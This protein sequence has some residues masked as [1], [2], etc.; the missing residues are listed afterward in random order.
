MS[1]NGINIARTIKEII[2][3]YLQ[4]LA[5]KALGKSAD[6]IDVT[7]GFFD[8]GMDSKMTMQLVSALE[9]KVGHELYPTLLFEYQ[10]IED[11]G[12]YLLE[13]DKQA[14]SS[15]AMEPSQDLGKKEDPITTTV[16]SDTM[17]VGQETIHGYLQ[18]LAGEALDKPAGSIDVTAGFFDL[19]MDSKM[20]MQL[21]STLEDK[22][23]HELYPTLLFEYQNIEDLSAY[24]LEND[25]EA[26]AQTQKEQTITKEYD[27][28]K[29]RP[30]EN[31][32]EKEHLNIET[33]TIFED[34]QLVE[35]IW[36]DIPVSTDEAKDR[37]NDEYQMPMDDPIAIV[38]ISGRYP[39]ANTI[40]EFWDNLKTGK[41]SISAMPKDRWDK[42]ERYPEELLTGK[43]GGFIEDVD[44]FDPLHF[45]IAP[46]E[47]EFIDPQVRLF[48]EES[49]KTF[50]DAGLCLST[51]KDKNIGVF[52]G[53]MFNSY[54]SAAKNKTTTDKLSFNTGWT[55]AN[56][57]SYHL[58]LTGPSMHVNT[59]CSSSLT[60]VIEACQSIQNGMCTSAIAGG[61][62]LS[63]DALKWEHLHEFGLLGSSTTS[64]SFAEGDGYL[65]GEGVG[66]VLLKPLSKAEQDGDR[67]YGVIK[68]G[69]L[70]H[71]GAGNGFT[72][73]NLKAQTALIKESLERSGIDADAIG[74]VEAAANGSAMG[75]P[76]EI[77]ALSHLFSSGKKKVAI[78]SVKAQIGHL[79]SASG[80]SQLTKVLLQLKH[81]TLVPGIKTQ[82][83]NPNL[84]LKRTSLEINEDLKEWKTTGSRLAMVN[85]F[86]AGGANAHVVVEEYNQKTKKYI[87]NEPAMV[88]LSAKNKDRLKEQVDNLYGFLESNENTNLYDLAYTL[89]IGR[90]SMEE[91]FVTMV[92]TISELKEAL[93]D[94]QRGETTNCL[95]G[96]VQNEKSD[97]ILKGNAGKA[98]IEVAIRDKEIESLMQLWVKGVA[99]DWS[100][101][102]DN[103]NRPNKI[104]LP[105][106]PFAKES[107]WIPELDDNN[108]G[109]EKLHPLLHRNESDFS[110]QKYESTFTGKESFLRNHIAEDKK[111]LPEMA[112]IELAREAGKR[113][114]H[115]NI[116]QLKDVSWSNPISVNGKPKQIHIS[117][118]ED[119]EEINYE[120]YSLS[121][122]KGSEEV[123]HGKGKLGTETLN[124]PT[125][126]D[127][128]SIKEQLPNYKDK[129]A[130]HSLFKALGLN[131]G[132]GFIGIESLHSG[133][134][135]ALVNLSIPKENS[136]STQL[137]V[138][139]S[140][141]QA[142]LSL[143]L[144]A[145]TLNLPSSIKGVY[146]Y[147]DI[148]TV[149]WCYILKQ[150]ENEEENTA[151]CE[152]ELLSDTG[153]VVLRLEDFTV[154]KIKSSK[155]IENVGA[156]KAVGLHTYQSF[157]R[158]E[159]PKVKLET[160]YTNVTLLLAGGNVALAEK[161]KDILELDVVAI[162]E[163]T[164]IEY[165]NEV[166]H[167]VKSKLK[168]K[169]HTHIIVLYANEN[170][171]DYG[172]VSGLLKTAHLESPKITG[173]T[174]GI[175]ELSIAEIDAL[176][177]VIGNEK[178]DYSI[179]VRYNGGEREVKKTMPTMVPEINGNANIKEGGVYLITGGAGGLGYIFARHIS[180]KKDAKLILTGR[181]EKCKL[182]EEALQTINATYHSCDVNSEVAVK[183]LVDKVVD[184]YGTIDGIIHGAGII[185]DN[186]LIQKTKEEAAKVLLPKINGAKNLDQATKTLDLDFVMY[187][188]SLSGVLGN[189][190]QADYSSANSWM[191]NYAQYRNELKDQGKRKG[192]TLS[193]DW[194]LWESGGM[195]IDEAT[196]RY[197]EDK[198]GMQPL[199]TVEGVLAFEAFLDNNVTQGV[200]AYG[201]V[202]KIERKLNVERKEIVEEH[203]N[204]VE[205]DRE[206]LKA[207][208]ENEVT[209][210]I[211]S[212][213]KLDESRL[214]KDTNFSDYGVESAM[215]TIFSKTLNDHYEGLEILPIAFVNN[216][217]INELVTFLMEE[218]TEIII[219]KG[220]G[221]I[222]SKEETKTG[223]VLEPTTSVTSNKRKKRFSQARAKQSDITS[224]AVAI[225]GMSGRFSTIDT[226]EELWSNT[227]SNVALQ[228]DGMTET[229]TD[230]T[231]GHLDI[232]DNGLG[233]PIL[234]ISPKEASQM[235]IQEQLIFEELSKT[236]ENYGIDRKDLSSNATGVFIAAQEIYG[237]KNEIK[238]GQHTLAYLIPNKISYYLNLKGPSE[239]VNAYCTSSYV[240]IHKAIQ[241]IVNGE[242]K[243]A[244]VGGVN[245]VSPEE[246][247]RA[248]ASDFGG[249]FSKKGDTRSFSEDAEGFV[250]SEG[251]GV[252]IIKPL[253]QAEKDKNKIL[254]LVKGSAVHHGGKGFSIEA[255]NARGIKTAIEASIQKSRVSIDTIDYIEAHGI[256]N[257][258]A[259]AIELGAIDA[260]YKKFSKD[261][262]KKWHVGT[263]KPIVGHSELASGMASLIKVLK[264]F[265]H[266]TIPGIAGLENINS[267]LDP[268]HSLILTKESCHWQ[269]GT[270]PRRAG[271]NSYAV[272]GVNAHLI[273]EEYP[274]VK[275]DE[276]PI[277]GKKA[278]VK[279]EGKEVVVEADK[280]QTK[281]ETTRETIEAISNEIFQ[282][283]KEDFDE[284]LSPIDYD[285]DS[286]KVIEFV[287]RI[288]EHFK[289]NVKMGQILGVDD[290][291]SMYDAFE[292]IVD[293]A[294]NTKGDD[295]V[296]VEENLPGSYPL[297]EGQKGLWFIQ[298]ANP[299]STEYNVPLAFSVNRLVD[300]TIIYKAAE[301][302]LEKEPVLRVAF[303]VDNGNGELIQEIQ[304]VSG[305][306]QEDDEILTKEIGQEFETLQAI[307]FELS[308][309][310]TR[311]HIRQDKEAQR[312][313]ILFVVHHIVFDGSSVAPFITGFKGLLKQL[314]SGAIPVKLEEERPYFEF[315]DQENRY[316]KSL[317]SIEDFAFWSK[318]FGNSIEKVE[319]PYDV[320][321]K[322]SLNPLDKE[323]ACSME[324]N[325]EAL[326]QLKH[327]AKS[328]KVNLSVFML[329]MFKVLLYKITNAEEL[330][331]KLP[332]AGRPNEKY[333]NSIGYYINM[334]LAKT[335]VSGDDA[336]SNLVNK[337]KAEFLS[338][339]DYAKYPYPKLLTSLEATKGKGESLF[340]IVYIY[341]NI[342][343]KILK[344]D[345]S[346]D[347]TL[348]DSFRQDV[349]DEYV[350]EII[351]LKESLKVEFKYKK[352][353]FKEETVNAHINYY[354]NIIEEVIANPDQKVDDMAILSKEEEQR[355]L[356]DFNA[357]ESIYPKNKSIVELF[358]DQVKEDPKAIAVVFG[359]ETITYETLEERSNQLATYL[360]QQGVGQET[361][362]G[363]CMDRSIE[364]MVA[365]LGVL[366]AGGAYV[367]IDSEY[368]KDRISYMLEDSIVNG[369][370]KNDVRIILVQEHLKMSILD[371]IDESITAITLLKQWDEN[372]DITYAKGNLE[373]KTTP[374]S[375]AYVIYTSGSTGNPKGVMVEHKSVVRLV[376]NP[377]Y[378]R[379]DKDVTI[380]ATGAFSFDATIFEFFGPLLNGGKLIL[381]SQDVLLNNQS[382]LDT[383]K[384]NKVD[385]M[386]FTSSWLN[387]I[388]DSNI[389]VFKT[390][391]TV[392]V[393]GERL[394]PK[395]IGELRT[396]YPKLEIING[397]GPTENT[398]F[399]TTNNIKEVNGDI[400]IGKPISDDKAYIVNKNNG[401]QP[402][403]VPGELCLTGEGLSRGYLNRKDLTDEKFIE[404]PFGKGKLYRT[405]DLARWNRNG[406]IEYLGRIDNQVKLRGFRI[407]LG[408]I[409]TMLNSQNSI[410]NSTVI[411]K[412]HVGSKQLVAYCVLADGNESLDVLELKEELAKGLPDYMVPPFIVEIDAL[413]L[414]SNGK[415]DRRALLNL[416]VELRGIREYVA[417]S[418]KTEKQLTAIWE[419]VL[420]VNHISVND[421]FFELG[422][423]SLLVTKLLSRIQKEFNV[424]L[425]L[426]SV[427]ESS[428]LVQLAKTVDNNQGNQLP[429]IKVV[430][431]REKQ[432]LSFA[433]QRLWFLN[434]LGEGNRY[435]IPYLLLIKG[436]LDTDILE[437][438]LAYLI[439][440]HEI[441]RTT[442]RKDEKDEAYQYIAEE[443]FFELT[444][445][446]Y[447]D[448]PFLE[449][450]KQ[451]ID[452]YMAFFNE[453]F[454]LST[455][456]LLRGILIEQKD[457][458]YIFG[459]CMH[460]IVSD[461]WS[462]EIIIRE[463]NEIYASYENNAPVKLPQLPVQYLDYTMWQHTLFNNSDFAKGL[464]YWKTHLDGYVDLALPLDYNRPKGLSGK[465]KRISLE[466]DAS[467]KTELTKFSVRSGGTLFTTLLTSVYV[468]L[469]KYSNQEDICV[470]IPVANRPLGA[471][472]NVIGFFVNTLVNRIK[473]TKEDSILEIFAKVQK[474]L[475]QSQ[476]NQNIPFEKIVEAIQPKREKNKAPIFQVMVN[477]AKIEEQ[478]SLGET[479]ISVER[480]EFDKVKFD[481]NFDFMDTMEGGVILSLDY[482]TDIFKPSTANRFLDG[483]QNIL[484]TL[485]YQPNEQLKSFNILTEKERNLLLKGFNDKKIAY[486]KS[487]CIHDLF[488]LQANRTPKAIALVFGENEI[489]YEELEERSRQLA[490]YL[491]DKGIKSDTLV[492]ICMSRSIE[493]VIAMLGV[494][495][496][497]GAYI[498]IDSDYPEDRMSFMINDGIVKGNNKEAVRLILTQEHLEELLDPMV[499]EADVKIE[500]ISS[501]WEN[502][503]KIITTEGV[504]SPVKS[505]NDLAY[506]IYTSGSTGKPKGVLI[507]HRSFLD[508]IQYQKEFFEVDDKDQFLQFSNFS[509][510]AS[511]E[512]I[513]LPLVSG[514]TLHIMPKTDLLDMEKF[515]RVLVG[516][517]ITHLHAVPSFL[518]EIPFV[519]NTKLKRIISGGDVFDYRVLET[520]GDQGIRIID[521][522][523]PTES[524]VS[525]VQ[526]DLELP[527]VEKHIGKPLANTC[528]YVLDEQGN[529]QP[530][531]VP[532]ELCIGG[533][534]LARGYLNRPEL[535][536]EKFID[537]PFGEGKIYKTG[538]LTRWLP[539]GNIE[540]LGRIDHQVKVNGFRIELE[541]IEAVINTNET[542]HNSVVI[543]KEHLGS[544][545]LVAYCVLNEKEGVFS[546]SALKEYLAQRL[547]EYMIPAFILVVDAIPLT[548]NRKVN[549]KEL[550]SRPLI[551]NS[552][553]QYVAPKTETEKQ[554]AV[555]WQD[556][557]DVEKISIYDNFFELGGHSL[558]ITKLLS[559][560]NKQFQV[561]LELSKVFDTP[562][563]EYL[564]RE[565]E[566]SDKQILPP[567][568]IVKD[569]GQLPL[570]YAQQR[571]W[572]LAQLGQGD[573]YH[574]PYVL[575]ING[576]LDVEALESSL[577]HLID[578]HEILRTTFQV[579]D[580]GIA[581]Q[582][583]VD[584]LDLSVIKVDY[585]AMDK[586]LL[587][588]RVQEYSKSFIAKP[589]NLSKGPLLRAVIIRLEEN[590]C[591][592]GLCMHHIISDGWSMNVMINEL[593][594]IY[595]SYVNNREIQ[596]EGLSVQYAD[597]SLWQRSLFEKELFKD[598]LSHWEHHL[599][600]YVD[601]ELPTDYQRPKMATG[602]GKRIIHEFS[603][604]ARKEL[605]Q[606]GIASG[607]TLFT[608]LLTS[609]YVLLYKYSGQN[610][611]C[612]GVPTANRSHG[613][614]EG[615]VGFF[616][617]TLVNRIQFSEEDSILDVFGKVQAELVRSQQYQHIPF[618]KVVDVVKPER[619][620]SR[621]PIFQVMV[622][623][624]RQEEVLHLEN[625]TATPIESLEYDSS[626]FDLTF[627][628]LD[629][630][631]GQLSLAIEYNTDIYS[632]QT[633]ERLLQGIITTT[634]KII[635]QP[636]LPLEEFS[637]VTE[638]EK[639][640]QLIGFNATDD[641]Y[642]K[643]QLIHE[644]FEE[645][646]KQTPEDIA[647]I[648]GTKEISYQELDIQSNQ[649][650]HY[651]KGNHSI[652]PGVLVGVKLE[653]DEKLL[654][655]LLA[656]LKLGAAY[657]PLDVDYPA[658][659]IEYIEK[660]SNCIMLVDDETYS[661]YI[662]KEKDC[663]I[664]TVLSRSSSTDIAYVIY[665]SGTTGKPKGVM[666]T[667]QNACALIHWAKREYNPGS[668]EIVYGTTSHCFDLSVFEMFYALSIGKKI[669]ILK[670][671]LEI[672]DY[673]TIDKNILINTVPSSI[674]TVLDEGLDL[675]N[676]AVINLAGEPFPV[677]VAKRLQES[678]AEV[679][680]LYGPSEDTTY[681]TCYKLDKNKLYA[682]IP[683]GS[684]ILNTKAYV[685]DNKCQLLPVGVSGKLYL[686]GDGVAKGYLNKA[687]LT[688]ERFVPNPFKE[689]GY[690]YDTGDIVKWL[691]DGKLD[692]LGRADDQVKIRGYRIELGEIEITLNSHPNVKEGVVVA[693]EHLG[694][695][696]LVAYCVLEAEAVFD[697][698]ELKRHLSNSLPDYMVPGFIMPIELI[699]LTPNRK[700]DR[701]QLMSMDLEVTSIHEY[702][703]PRT[704]LEKQLVTIWEE[705][706]GLDRVGVRDNFFELGGNSLLIT[707]LLS[708]IN[709]QFQVS[710]E[711]S[712]I[713][714][715]P[716][717]EYLA[718]EIGTSSRQVLTSIE[719]VKDRGQLPL[720]YAQQRLWFL[721]QLGQGDRY[722]IPC[723]LRI[724]GLLDVEALENSLNY[725]INR[726]ETLRTTFHLDDKGMAYQHITDQL[727]ISMDKVDY[728][729]EEKALLE[730][731]IQEYSKS[732][733]AKP[734]DLS[735]GPL[736]RAVIIRLSENEHVFGLCMHHIISDGWSINIM[737]NEL[738][739]IYSACINKQ[740]VELEPLL[741]QYGDYTIW[742]RKLFEG[743]QFNEGLSHWEQHLEGYVDLELPTDFTRPKTATG[744]G[745]QIV[746][747][748]DEEVRSK[749]KKF[750]IA[751]GGTLF[752]SLLTSVYILLHKYSGQDDICIGL[753]VA[754]RSQNEVE[755]LIGF[756]VNTLVNRLQFDGEDTLLKVFNNV[757]RELIRSQEH[758]DIPFNK[759]VEA[760]QPERQTGKT[761]IFQV[762][763]NYVQMD[764][765]FN[766]GKTTI[767]PMELLESDTAKFDLS[768]SF[769]ESSNSPVRLAL[770]Y[771]TDIYSTATAKKLLD[772]L[773]RI[774]SILPQ[775][776]EIALK[777][778]DILAGNERK[779]LLSTFNATDDAYDETSLIH[780][781]F[782]EQAKKTP[783]AI[784]MVCGE[785]TMSYEELDLQSN[786]LAHYISENYAID[787]KT[788]IGARLERDEKL[789]ITL[790]AILKTGAAYVPL[791]VNY[792]EER[793]AYIE[794]D[795][796]CEL[797]I[798]EVIYSRYL[799]QKDKYA[800]TS[801]KSNCQATDN[802][803]VI[804]TSGT[805]GKPK[806]VTITHKNACAL[807]HWC[808]KEYDAN[809]FDIVYAA[810][811]HC[812]D[813]SIYEMFYTLSIGKTIRVLNNALDIGEHIGKDE[814]ILIN[815]VPS[816]IRTIM[817]EGMDFSNVT[818]INLAGEPFP[819]DIAKR[820]QKSN[821]EVRNLYGP[822][823]DT[824]YSTCYKLDDDEEYAS[825]PIGRPILNTKAYI[826]DKNNQLVPMGVVGQLYLSGDGV[827][828]GYLNKPELTEERFVVNPFEA[829]IMMYDT[830]DLAKWLPDGNIEYLG[831]KDN[832][833][834]IRG[835]R[836]EL[837]EI[838]NTLNEIQN[839]RET[840]VIAKEHLG[841]KHLIAY[842]VVEDEDKL[843]IQEIKNQMANGLPDY[844]IPNFIIPLDRIPLTPN[845]KID[846]KHLLSKDLE[847]AGSSEYVAASTEI[848]GQLVE[849][850]KE[851]LSLEQVGIHDNF[852]ELGGH[853]LLTI[854]LIQKIKENIENHNVQL[855]ELINN[856]TIYQQALLIDESEGKVEAKHLVVF[857]ESKTQGSNKVGTFIIPG[858]PGIVDGYYELA[859]AFV[860]EGNTVHG[861]QM[862]GLQEGEKPLT[863]IEEMASHNIEIIK[864]LSSRKIRLVAHSYG[865][866]VLF[867]MM[868]QLSGES[869]EVV[870]VILLDS[871]LPG[872]SLKILEKT[873][874]FVLAVMSMMKIEVT[875]KEILDFA[876]KV[877]KK[878][879]KT[880]ADSIYDFLM[881]KGAKM[882]RAFFLRVFEIYNNS[883]N[884]SYQLQDNFDVDAVLITARQT[885]GSKQRTQ[886]WTPYFNTIQVIESSG[887]H[888]ELVKKPFVSKWKR[889][890]ANLKYK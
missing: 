745:R 768:F 173:K 442:F 776:P 127:V 617:N 40:A 469:H 657:V 232:K 843:D 387:Q 389:E 184:T 633:V 861:I 880:R 254:G 25:K 444:K 305:Y 878:L 819:V 717:L 99:I 540:F 653:R 511:V 557:L 467:I 716:V 13:N 564:S 466:L 712:K 697:I 271:L 574:V 452:R 695:K 406:Q 732:F 790:L 860:E 618:D 440:R 407:E 44:K 22:V 87:G 306:L 763:V 729:K 512:Q 201:T 455:G 376:K 874:G 303:K 530:L 601:L 457:N 349:V 247:S 188:A 339:I 824:T 870:E 27:T 739:E 889:E 885:K 404:N 536:D 375:L 19:G 526:R 476:E 128:S 165:Y 839:I 191:D 647:V 420:E 134:T 62:N 427:F 177:D 851:V 491:Q 479:S 614:I 364:M 340:P 49:W 190:G 680:N 478:L 542:I 111:V 321:D 517:G 148:D 583:I 32:V 102:Y 572:F 300:T 213:L 281:H 112:Y 236:M 599:K 579:D 570:S 744:Q 551:V 419:E 793:I 848:E 273:L 474:E 718:K 294:L 675:S 730:T 370:A 558:L 679:R 153:E 533:D 864:K 578:R 332:T 834:K 63:L 329:S 220:Q 285:F 71:N 178:E 432:P 662:K 341:Q 391:K 514:S 639:E 24:L 766:L 584:Q 116:T 691:P 334:M 753:P 510:D 733:I 361:L 405:G 353:L 20:T 139:D 888:F 735:E 162:N 28:E 568:E 193:I 372:K 3:V 773:M 152:I 792:P 481:L 465:G 520:W 335:V 832:Q 629:S 775:E 150:N 53:S 164:E 238:G 794:K 710:L 800:I 380:L 494:L 264:A 857:N 785:R 637:L 74:Y 289:V 41:D 777:T 756:F 867:E 641:A 779:Q 222:I 345:S 649:F 308:K 875:K 550:L 484:T 685:L 703:A 693:K 678:K 52:V 553:E 368:P 198:W 255:P 581:C 669:R 609:A 625:T 175:E 422:G 256:A 135:S 748:L 414:T 815:T 868:R 55:I 347:I 226:E 808:T 51:T 627:S 802:A 68:G 807:V 131:Y 12:I 823:E 47:A 707:K 686:S 854:Q 242:C 241:S 156:S 741:V 279:E 640:Q 356:V 799:K 417:P 780:V 359:E 181:S 92:N 276:D 567:I 587:E 296:V 394:S 50:E 69:S 141:I 346:D 386:W 472:E 393:G 642:D 447:G 298:N 589:F 208:V 529:I 433:Q 488:E 791:D 508:L 397:Y 250:R 351:D 833:V 418:T 797:V 631:E 783:N 60:A 287:N 500:S 125:I 105:G 829:G 607:G 218:H 221:T 671:A 183:G 59:A 43:W 666:I 698:Q 592:F 656:I 424:N 482:S 269:N 502:N 527:L 577:N 97:F 490:I 471:I 119:A 728:S 737:V 845:K 77:T 56:R 209:G 882:N 820:L 101:I 262:S 788:L 477:Y 378:Y 179:E 504:L 230:L 840:V 443:S 75:D 769:F 7:A 326:V 713:F 89:Q 872:H 480:L 561:S 688:K 660:D 603:E 439:N 663:A 778:F 690:M 320:I 569:R 86:G 93:A 887:T 805:T 722:H 151:T 137:G 539:E 754:N 132:S 252:I 595:S 130:C 324:I 738:N 523:G 425:L 317:A 554:L 628:F 291:K 133:V 79:E 877:V 229:S 286:I 610:D 26:F 118:F 866:V 411:I 734:F 272:G 369:N 644:L 2:H 223:V 546:V 689:G 410:S 396:V 825:V 309:T 863:T 842:C 265:E 245:L 259:D 8:L 382:L 46:A 759:I 624:G 757:Q 496:S 37:S 743:K 124:K 210:L 73:P 161:L 416:N 673:A 34:A 740:N 752:T 672:G 650:A 811:S 374:N 501:N 319:L 602:E 884:V 571:L 651:L 721:A 270:H 604:T 849:I 434:E 344:Q 528:C 522:Y 195:K 216:P 261:P 862:L 146:V 544:T 462:I 39:G 498:P 392:L 486:P 804:Y 646:V 758:Q 560:I 348:L 316:L 428:T 423:H 72:V 591:V 381:T 594:A 772:G 113:S 813:L 311:L 448:L 677:D 251:A 667:H 674:R 573:R 580:N 333:D 705:I 80:I 85:N 611:I 461:G 64:R 167:I 701:K 456:P 648:C 120:I 859:E 847:I 163:N 708:R 485:L 9:D 597:Y 421:S 166:Q 260:V 822:S 15:I 556:L 103:E 144:D 379:F 706:L 459:L 620:T 654:I 665:T 149:S 623:Y 365:I 524:T 789:I 70:N 200:V 301:L 390:L 129:A 747:E 249:L 786:R 454:D 343:D 585:S 826:L 435:H 117:L 831:R 154:Q 268:N 463:L 830:G 821:A 409:E 38:G 838:E 168:T 516:K 784:A 140:A 525:A 61:V 100:L 157:W 495:R 492:G 126:V 632:I 704:Q 652:E 871:H 76:I 659:R 143:A 771:N 460:H 274:N 429:E 682:S 288:N 138:L 278:E 723:V 446:N 852:F 383:I 711:L 314:E 187:C 402:I 98:Y 297:S 293:K 809:Q 430:N 337:V 42:N 203:E 176:V 224:E 373:S 84:G 366:K 186:F 121:T 185:S 760:L 796:N 636:Q 212:I 588:T 310:V 518:K 816:S 505:L 590:E 727:D 509:F 54:P 549:R 307:P 122:T 489:S 865:G 11:L 192:H 668:F 715:T 720:S 202:N 664:T 110:E 749:L 331:V 204:A 388:V 355:I 155:K 635:R 881:D 545:Q 295:E 244:I 415:V 426:S 104:S 876:E 21:V 362:V 835:Y 58:G 395:H 696:Q 263:S 582:Y 180:K 817:D 513:Y 890:L 207:K 612:V 66:A 214:D 566:D 88:L 764:A 795:S 199:P 14:F 683:I 358:G 810:T 235:S 873:Q 313:Y 818:L 886:D 323:G 67:I 449:R 534:G 547:P 10:N 483:L 194:P 172:F 827:A 531:G 211:A 35:D 676:L 670:N 78:G 315:I 458:E 621:T 159:N 608:S 499:R 856:P 401:L 681:S 855:V 206:T 445:E 606:F 742:Q 798:D 694:S 4:G 576:L 626:K 774:I 450:K 82:I 399:S 543:A 725:L 883:I 170:Y 83:L 836:I 803:Y 91:R 31:N 302:L 437:K 123:V 615:V 292:T 684:P 328:M 828:K 275:I 746:L 18:K 282:I 565:I 1:S 169:A 384:K 354:Q 258:M 468:L 106:Y 787:E 330:I 562:V 398:T 731:R 29:T 403:G 598:G 487:S 535:T 197:L 234:N 770:G 858:M 548:P 205:I 266:K 57:V 231:F 519:P 215:V 357:S 475:I 473:L 377:D 385:V 709:K 593:N 692:Y 81:K 470:G 107:Y 23:G 243:Q 400:A 322:G 555:I 352:A 196:K 755:G 552:Q 304:P 114:L 801:L 506:V 253:Q 655:T 751:S 638:E 45:K 643:D 325:G 109:I 219:R 846:R 762:M 719:V 145:G 189:V 277:K 16:N 438:S 65:P 233:W 503:V 225:V 142:S 248:V 750:S 687:E 726:H 90:E 108:G 699:P 30:I 645:Q 563:L 451:T 431:N 327:A 765:N 532:G 464:S 290:F 160:N 634:E 227:T 350:L 453:P 841:S 622:N 837:G 228:L 586:N 158:Q 136:Y 761:P 239:I 408:E 661:S 342:F 869:I 267:E 338:N 171:V 619:V 616:V 714:D 312:T 441:L 283:A 850:W 367:P 96:N 538:D 5:G 48:L 299:E 280:A 814:K 521:K 700:I 436:E 515:K 812:F 115:Q 147:G 658:E 559:R 630:K 541:E 284:T 493:M 95:I 318:K 537:N 363:I 94:F 806:G 257:R 736:L 360:Q 781:L 702:V 605:N 371:K 412:E 613:D 336:F 879:K 575:R 497:G 174:V 767:T 413:P 6:S 724:S 596:L 217:T 600:G 507:E 782:E 182:S 853:S 246:M 240:A 33:T 17:E 844:M 237:S 36:G